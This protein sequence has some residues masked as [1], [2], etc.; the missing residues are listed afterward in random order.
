MTVVEKA[1]LDLANALDNLEAKLETR[2]DEGL[3]N[4]EQ[5]EAARRHAQAAQAHTKTASSGLGAAISDLK[6]LLETDNLSAKE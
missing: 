3:A 6:T 2:L 5:I 1:V 4:T